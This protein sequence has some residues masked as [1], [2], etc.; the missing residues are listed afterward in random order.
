M[1]A[2]FHARQSPRAIQAT[3]LKASAPR[4]VPEKQGAYPKGRSMRGSEGVLWLFLAW[5]THSISPVI[6]WVVVVG[7]ESRERIETDAGMDGQ[8]PPSSAAPLARPFEYMRKESTN[9][10]T[11]QE[12]SAPTSKGKAVK[13]N[14][15]AANLTLI[16]IVCHSSQIYSVAIRRLHLQFEVDWGRWAKS[17]LRKPSTGLTV[18]NR[19]LNHCILLKRLLV[20][21]SDPNHAVINSHLTENAP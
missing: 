2:T 13:V 11:S 17:C 1:P 20:S 4:N 5:T 18:D 3:D 10:R 19:T 8:I 9:R 6:R 16:N 7:N 15:K 21:F 12:N 14:Y